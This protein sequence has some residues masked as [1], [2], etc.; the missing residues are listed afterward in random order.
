MIRSLIKLAF[1]FPVFVFS[2]EVK[3]NIVFLLVDDV[4]WGDFGCYGANFNE[5]P[6]ID[7][8][9]SQGM[10]FTNGYAACTVCSPSRAAILTGKYP[11]RT[12]LTDWIDGHPYPHAKLKVPDWTMKMN[13]DE[14]LLPEALKEGGYNTVFLGKWHLMPIGQE[15]F[16]SHYPTNHGFDINIAGREWGAPKGRGKY[17]SPFDM[18]NLDNGK[19]D[20][21][22]TDKLTDA[23]VT[24]LDTINKEK[25]FLLYFSYYTIHG[26][27]MA[28]KALISKYEE[29]AKTFKNTKN[30]YLNPARAGMVEKLDNSVGVLMQKLENLGIA[31]NTIVILT[32]DNGGNYDETTNGLKGYKGF[33]HEGGTREPFLVKWPNKV[34][35]G[36]VCNEKVIGTDFYPTILDMAGLKLK[37][38]QHIDGLSIMPLLTGK[39]TKLKRDKLYWHYPHYHRTKPYGAIRNGDWKL[40][41]FFEDGKLELYNLKTD[42]NET[43][44]I[45]ES[46][47]NKVKYLLKDLKKWRKSVGAQMMTPNPNYNAELADKRAKKKK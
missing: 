10:L 3:P 36:A 6:N 14:V 24:I 1:L 13:H 47:P 40:I 41:E 31:D 44:N 21:F 7:K 43:L 45:S 17:F 29:K 12:H 39:K 23:A 2:Q 35:A 11:A 32:G 18:P 46:N 33:S 30:E 38:K 25:P 8:L 34:K 15:D 22:L 42:P 26:P 28:P 9:S 20:D 16:E 19:K 37:P 4:G 27:I 5:T